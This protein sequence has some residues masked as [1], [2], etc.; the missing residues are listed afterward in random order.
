LSPL[1]RWL[2]P[3]Y[4]DTTPVLDLE[5]IGALE[6]DE[7]PA[8][9]NYKSWVEEVDA[10]L[11]PGES[12]KVRA[13]RAEARLEEEKARLEVERDASVAAGMRMGYRLPREKLRRIDA[14]L[15]ALDEQLDLLWGFLHPPLF[16]GQER[17]FEEALGLKCRWPGCKTRI[18]RD[19]SF[20][21]GGS[22]AAHREVE[23]L[24]A[25]PFDRDPEKTY[26]RRLVGREHNR[27]DVK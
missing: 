12:R 20:E 11:V 21:T 2:S 17:E 8:A 1:P 25:E 19:E 16:N 4:E 6:A 27:R 15:D 18:T 23:L 26:I 22:C 3:K 7:S 24:R 10:E 14:R 13:Q 5:R 9:V